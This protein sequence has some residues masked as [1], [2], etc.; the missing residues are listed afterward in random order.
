MF[1]GED[2]DFL[3]EHH[4][5][6]RVTKYKIY[7]RK[8]RP[9]VRKEARQEEELK[10]RKEQFE[11]KGEMQSIIEILLRQDMRMQ[12]GVMDSLLQQKKKERM[13]AKI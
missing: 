8:E 13:L 5:N 11:R 2:Y 3:D 4:N 1:T 9:Y 6:I 12:K 7:A 10:Y